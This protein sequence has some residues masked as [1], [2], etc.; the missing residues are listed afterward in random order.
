[1]AIAFVQGQSKQNTSATPQAFSSLTAATSGNLLVAVFACKTGSSGSIT[2]VT[3]SHSS[4]WTFRQAGWV[5]GAN[6]RCEIWT[7]IAAGAV[8]SVTASVSSGFAMNLYLGEFSTG[9][10]ALDFGVFSPNGTAAGDATSD[11]TFSGGTLT[12]QTGAQGVYVAGVSAPLTTTA[13]TISAP[14]GFTRI[15]AATTNSSTLHGGEAAYQVIASASGG[16]TANFSSTVAATNGWA[17]IFIAEVTTTISFRDAQSAVGAPTATVTKPTGTVD[18]DLLVCSV[19]TS[20]GGVVTPPSGFTLIRSTA[21]NGAANTLAT[22]YKVASGEGASYAITGSTSTGAVIACFTGF[23]SWATDGEGGQANTASASVTAPTISP[24]AAHDLL[25]WC[26]ASHGGGAIGAPPGLTKPTNGGASDSVSDTTGL[27]YLLDL[28]ASG[29]TG[30]KVGTD[31]LAANAGHL[32]AFTVGATALNLAVPL[33]TATADLNAPA[34]QAIARAPLSTATGAA[35]VPVVQLRPAPGLMTATGAALAPTAR[36][37]VN[38]PLSTATGVFLTPTLLLAK[39]IAVPLMTATGA[40]LTPVMQVYVTPAAMAAS[41]AALAPA[42]RALVSPAA[43]S[44]SGAAFAPTL[45]ALVNPAAMSATGA[46]LAPTLRLLVAPPLLTASAG[47]LAPT[48][49]LLLRP[50]VMTATGIAFAPAVPLSLIF[51]VPLMSANALLLPPAV[52]VALRPAAMTAT[53]QMPAPAL[54]LARFFAVP[55]MTMEAAFIAPWRAGA[56]ARVRLLG[57][58]QLAPALT[59]ALAME[60]GPRAEGELTLTAALEGVL[61]LSPLALAGDLEADQAAIGDFILEAV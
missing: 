44:A 5:S 40:A 22:Y 10:K 34:V 1:M 54:Y 58:A 56:F 51:A 17:S 7:A 43:M 61:D 21:F 49:Q 57:A 32:V 33:M 47:L 52:Q 18:G 3:D 16:V 48:V 59:A 4:V 13:A 46:A 24:A 50:A 23:A 28:I 29:A 25:V 36:F 30:T 53:G 8:T 12:P 39:V 9:G 31:T 6:S 20:S 26:G 60:P 41:A 19:V 27:A 55:T 35:L 11:T 42:V 38:A 37:V 2:G 15:G 45:Q 14:A